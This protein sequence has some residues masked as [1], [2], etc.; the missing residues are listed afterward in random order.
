MLRAATFA[1]LEA[2]G[3]LIARSAHVLSVGDYTPAQV[4]AALRGT[5]G[6]DTQLLRDG[7]YYVIELNGHLAACGG[8]SY[9]ATLF[10]SDDRDHRDPTPLDPA[11]DAAK[12]R[13]FF[14]DPDHARQG[15]G[16]RLLHHCEAEA[17]ARGFTHFE[18]M[19]T[20][21]GERL[22]A[23]EGYIAGDRIE[24]PLGDNLVLPLIAMRK[25]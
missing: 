16:R 7:T 13:A 4:D 21:P 25:P 9:R 12:I 8:W 11:H 24:H 22:Y 15:L 1:D 23:A 6:T 17:R 19:A 10:G 14:V 20:V 2:I 3:A 5:F 18:L